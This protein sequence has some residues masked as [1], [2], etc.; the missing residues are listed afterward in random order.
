V[1]VK[2]QPRSA[3][4]WV[5]HGDANAWLGSWWAA[6]ASYNQA[7][8]LGFEE[9]AI[10]SR[11]GQVYAHLGRW[12]NAAEDFAGV[13]RGHP[14]DWQ[15]WQHLALLRLGQGD[16]AGYRTACRPLLSALHKGDLNQS[17]DSLIWSCVL[18]AG[19]VDDL[20]T[21]ARRAEQLGPLES[22]NYQQLNLRGAVHY[23]LGQLQKA[24]AFLEAARKA[25]GQEGTGWDLFFLAMAHHQLG[26]EKEAREWLDKAIQ[27]T[28]SALQR[29]LDTI[30]VFT[31]L[32]WEEKLELQILRR[33]A[34]TQLHSAKEG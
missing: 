27:W 18:G 4:L 10:Y 19:A 25:Q 21:L 17:S 34:E 5:Q 6:E 12:E 23:R 31:P 13:A 26:H 3:S 33:E 8:L 16:L 9:A 11:R 20:S 24:L 14:E 30:A 32:S 28:D 15:A 29:P 22:E 1:L 7:L 2:Q